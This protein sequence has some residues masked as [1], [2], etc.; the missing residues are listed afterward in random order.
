M[1]RSPEPII[2]FEEPQSKVPKTSVESYGPKNISAFNFNVLP[3]L[4]T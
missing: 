1:V 3:E 2:L 4:T